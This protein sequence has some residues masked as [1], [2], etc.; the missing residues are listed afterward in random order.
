MSKIYEAL[1]Q[2]ELDRAKVGATQSD[3]APNAQ[4]TSQAV[5]DREPSREAF[6]SRISQTCRL[7]SGIPRC[8]NSPHSMTGEALSSS[9]AV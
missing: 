5:L 1:R 4:T 7:S 9:F 8:P 6:P 2:A 3:S